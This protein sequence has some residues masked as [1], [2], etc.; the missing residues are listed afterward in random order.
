MLKTIHASQGLP[1]ALEPKERSERPIAFTATDTPASAADIDVDTGTYPS[2]IRM[3]TAK[4]D[5][6]S[7]ALLDAVIRDA[8]R[9][10]WIKSAD[11]GGRPPA[12]DQRKAM[13]SREPSDGRVTVEG[14]A[15][16]PPL[17]T[18]SNRLS[19][20]TQARISSETDHVTVGVPP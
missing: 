19:E 4:H 8:E 15:R 7:T 11:T 1:N 10:L 9:K 6:V 3:P 5:D 13:M 17:G 18:D 14:K 20:S 2:R 12:N 16:A